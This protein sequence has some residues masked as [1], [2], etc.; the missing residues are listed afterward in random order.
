MT[1]SDVGVSL[2]EWPDPMDALVPST[3]IVP[4]LRLMVGVLI[5]PSPVMVRSPATVT[6]L[7]FV[8]APSESAIV[9]DSPSA[10]TYASSAH[11]VCSISAPAAAIKQNTG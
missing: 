6:E 11:A 4:P 5:H 3:V 8:V 1:V 2:D 10:S 9:S 7:R